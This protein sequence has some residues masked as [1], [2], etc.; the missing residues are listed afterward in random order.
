MNRIVCLLV[1]FQLKIKFYAGLQVKKVL[2][3]LLFFSSIGKETENSKK[4]LLGDMEKRER[5]THMEQKWWR[6]FASIGLA[7]RVE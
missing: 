6:I 3:S 5:E 1:D 4:P 7:C 2:F